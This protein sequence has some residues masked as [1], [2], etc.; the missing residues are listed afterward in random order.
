MSRLA[1]TVGASIGVC[2]AALAGFTVANAQPADDAAAIEAAMDDGAAVY[3]GNCAVCHGDDGEG[4]E[5]PR[6]VGYER[7]EFVSATVGQIIEGG[8]YMPPFGPRLDDAEIAAV[9]TYIRN[10]WGN[11]F[12]LVTEEQVGAYR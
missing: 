6:L 11:E 10:S 4:G 12:G 8:A 5:G 7:L 1:T 2:L 9:A 3:E